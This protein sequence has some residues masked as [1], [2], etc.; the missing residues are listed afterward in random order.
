MRR[1]DDPGGS[2][3][4]ALPGTFVPRL[5]REINIKLLIQ[6]T[7]IPTYLLY[8]LRTYNKIYLPF[9]SLS[10][11]GPLLPRLLFNIGPNI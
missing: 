4:G 6:S 7:R 8:R 1:P 2:R 10:L 9:I 3:D 11:C 5:Y